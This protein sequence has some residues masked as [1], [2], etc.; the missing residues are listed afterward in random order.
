MYRYFAK[1]W[2]TKPTTGVVVINP[3]IIRR[4]IA[5]LGIETSCDDTGCAIVNENGDILGETLK[6]QQEIHL[7]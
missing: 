6:S 7:K 2:S 3:N 1:C 4:S 5:I